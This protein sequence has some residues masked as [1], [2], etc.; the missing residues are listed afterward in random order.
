MAEK[1]ILALYHY[2]GCG[3]CTRVRSAAE[4]LGVELELRNIHEDSQHAEALAAA[5]GRMTVPVLCIREAT[6]D[7]RWLPES[8]DIIDYLEELVG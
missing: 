5:M 3:F 1:E 6:G 7:I 4:E 2:T 8:E